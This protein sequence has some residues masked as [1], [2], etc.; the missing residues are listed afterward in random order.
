VPDFDVR[1]R[2][3]GSVRELALSHPAR[4]NALTDGLLIRL[5][6]EWTR[7]AHEGMRCILLRGEGDRAFS[8]GYDL[9]ALP[10]TGDGTEL[11]DAQLETTLDAIEQGPLPSVALLNGHAFGGGLDL[12]ARC[13]LRIAV[14]GSLLGMP[15]A[16][17]GL[18]YAPRGLARFQALLGPGATRRLF[19]TGAPISAAEALRLGLVDEVCP[20]LADAEERALTCAEEIAANAPLALFGLRRILGELERAALAGVDAPKAE[21]MRRVAFASADAREGREAFLAKRPPVFGGK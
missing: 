5:A 20:T 17:L 19:L 1:V 16:R 10:A 15:P 9:N 6:E 13:D 21:T 4:R 11:P 2:D 12:A 3:L 8:S 7:A 14:E 18:V